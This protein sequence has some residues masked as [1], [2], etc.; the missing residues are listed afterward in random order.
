MEVTYSNAASLLGIVHSGS[1]NIN[2]HYLATGLG[3]FNPDFVKSA[4]RDQQYRFFSAVRA[5]ENSR[6]LLA[7]TESER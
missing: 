7:A 5:R 4:P 2:I 1:T 3:R 6:T